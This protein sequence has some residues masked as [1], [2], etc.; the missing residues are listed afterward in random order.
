MKNARNLLIRGA[1]K[2]RRSKKISTEAIRQ[3]KTEEER[4][5]VAGHASAMQWIDPDYNAANLVGKAPE[6][7][8]LMAHVKTYDDSYF[9]NTGYT[10][11]MIHRIMFEAVQK[12]ITHNG[13]RFY[14]YDWEPRISA[15]TKTEYRP[16]ACQCW[17]KRQ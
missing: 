6:Q 2:Q 3:R 11:P 12:T 13:A 7:P 16:T 17:N 15:E 8:V 10:D 1:A 5:F 14:W 9:R 4:I